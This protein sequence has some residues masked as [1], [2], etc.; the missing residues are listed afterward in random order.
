MFLRHFYLPT[1]KVASK[2]WLINVNFSPLFLSSFSTQMSKLHKQLWTWF[3]V[4]IMD[5][6]FLFFGFCISRMHRRVFLKHFWF[7]HIFSTKLTFKVPVLATPNKDDRELLSLG[8]EQA[9][10]SLQESS[11]PPASLFQCFIVFPYKLDRFSDYLCQKMS[12]WFCME[13]QWNTEDR[14]SVV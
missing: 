2:S 11:T 9:V 4:S 1:V 13:K 8:P 5:K 12:N 14:K 6:M 3:K 10:T 7:Y